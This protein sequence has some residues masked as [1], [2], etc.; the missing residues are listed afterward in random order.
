MKTEKKDPKEKKP[1]RQVKS[2]TKQPV[3]NKDF[4]NKFRDET[5]DEN[6]LDIGKERLDRGDDDYLKDDDDERRIMSQTYK[7]GCN[8]SSA[9][10]GSAL[11]RRA[12]RASSRRQRDSQACTSA[13]ACPRAS[14]RALPRHHRCTRSN[15]AGPS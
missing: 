3:T 4:D 9:S 12:R 8:R 14:V 7:R 15:P 1:A 11:R 5:E 10:P 6:D 13:Y 2:K